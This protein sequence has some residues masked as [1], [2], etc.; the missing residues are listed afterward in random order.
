MVVEYL[1]GTLAKHISSLDEKITAVV[2][3]ISEKTA[4]EGAAR[5]VL[6][7]AKERQQASLEAVAV[8]QAELKTLQ[9]ALQ[10]AKRAVKVHESTV[11][12]AGADLLTA[13]SK[14]SQFKEILTDLADL[15][16]R[17]AHPEPT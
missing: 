13:E 3:E 16:D 12:Q 15:Q 8:A 4:A 14:L 6:E 11:S 17:V 1:E 2:A 10:H 5:E 9:T 7:A